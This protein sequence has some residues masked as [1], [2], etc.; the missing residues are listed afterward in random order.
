MLQYIYI[1]AYIIRTIYNIYKY[2]IY[3]LASGKFSLLI[4]GL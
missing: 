3:A 4:H 2:I 1:Y